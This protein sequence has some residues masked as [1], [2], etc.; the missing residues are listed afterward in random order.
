ML[1]T[2]FHRQK[3]TKE[4]KLVRRDL[5]WH[6]RIW[7]IDFLRAAIIIGML[8]DHLMISCWAIFPQLFQ[9][10]AFNQSWMKSVANFASNYSSGTF[11]V[12]L[13]L[14][15]VAALAFLVG[16][17]T[18]FSR[19]NLKRGLLVFGISLAINIVFIILHALDITSYILFGALNC[20]GLCILIYTGIH[21]LLGK[22]K[23]AWKWICLGIALFIFAGWSVFRVLVHRDTYTAS[24]N[25][26][27]FWFNNNPSNVKNIYSISSFKDFVHVVLGVNCY[28]EDWLGLFPYLGYMFLGAFVGLTVYKNKVSL[29]NRTAKNQERDLNYK[30]NKYGAWFNF[31]GHHT[32][33]IYALHQP[34]YIIIVI[35]IGLICGIPLAI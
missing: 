28:G 23:N 27:Y 5:N 2:C 20:Y 13:R 10:A 4:E 12:S 26:F 34:I 1:K 15:G 22:Y 29:L 7:E 17:N 35:I 33:W 21:K 3:L 16:I 18:Q 8:V 24:Q 32:L 6:R 14:F 30:F 19:N 25:N 11:R 9:T 31:F